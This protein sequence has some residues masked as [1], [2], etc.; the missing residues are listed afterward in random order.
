M[1]SLC[2]I[3]DKSLNANKH[4][5]GLLLNVYNAEREFIT[6][7]KI[8]SNALNGLQREKLAD[9]LLKNNAIKQYN[10]E[11]QTY[12]D[13]FILVVNNKSDHKY[14]MVTL[15]KLDGNDGDI[16]ND[17]ILT[18]SDDESDEFKRIMDDDIRDMDVYYICREIFDDRGIYHG[19]ITTFK[20][21]LTGLY[22]YK[23][24]TV[25]CDTGMKTIWI[26]IDCNR[27]K[28]L[29]NLKKTISNE[30]FNGLASSNIAILQTNSK[31]I[32]TFYGK[33]SNRKNVVDV[34]KSDREY[35][36]MGF[37]NEVS[38]LMNIF[39][40][41]IGWNIYCKYNE[42][43]MLL[44]YWNIDMNIESI[45]KEIII[46][47]CKYY[48]D[49]DKSMD[50]MLVGHITM[51]KTVHVIEITKYICNLYSN[52]II[53]TTNPWH[54]FPFT[55][56]QY[57]QILIK[58]CSSNIITQYNDN[59]FGYINSKSDFQYHTRYKKHDILLCKYNK[60]IFYDSNTICTNVAR[61]NI[62]T[63]INNNDKSNDY[64]TSQ[65]YFIQKDQSL[66]HLFQ[67]F[68]KDYDIDI[69]NIVIS[70]NCSKV[71]I[72]LIEKL[73]SKKDDVSNVSL[74]I[75]T[76]LE[77]FTDINDASNVN[78]ISSYIPIQSHELT[79]NENKLLIITTKNELKL[80]FDD[81]KLNCKYI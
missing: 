58:S 17:N 14:S 25:Y 38:E 11:N 78:N 7:V 68:S 51:D 32:N 3:K 70:K 81:F 21:Q 52:T 5:N 79:T 37:N 75:K 71:D 40:I 6:K 57:K 45:P 44:R 34:I 13:T 72:K 48:Y 36:V 28:Y 15:R 53:K 55:N 60:D 29:V 66:L 69:N 18:D 43:E 33:E 59:I 10:E 65:E 67:L 47:L 73:R 77:S 41:Y 50:K 8:K 12:F 80:I 54:L 22:Y 30:C 23:E 16:K 76:H 4:N 2:C 74:S 35:D 9:I 49:N 42:M 56:N 26:G 27:T 46:M 61:W 31:V 20:S 63:N 19:D 39:R 1:G 64:I 24:F 62:S